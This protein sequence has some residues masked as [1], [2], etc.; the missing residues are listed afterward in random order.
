MQ[1]RQFI[2][3]MRMQL[4]STRSRRQRAQTLWTKLELEGTYSQGL[5]NH[6]SHNS[7]DINSASGTGVTGYEGDGLNIDGA[8]KVV[9]WL[10]P[11]PQKATWK[12]L[13]EDMDVVRNPASLA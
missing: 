6:S 5:H 11:Q 2:E 1:V 3:L 8:F 7:P 12:L 13:F 4:H 10:I 9:E